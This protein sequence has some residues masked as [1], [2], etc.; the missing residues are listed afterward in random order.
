VAKPRKR[1]KHGPDSGPS[2]MVAEPSPSEIHVEHTEPAAA[3]LHP[4]PG[5]SASS[6]PSNEPLP[7]N[8]PPPNAEHN[9]PEAPNAPPAADTPG[10]FFS[11]LYFLQIN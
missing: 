6:Q 5:A 8:S 11:P 2:G 10:N 4:Q 3:Q 7:E 9:D 1:S